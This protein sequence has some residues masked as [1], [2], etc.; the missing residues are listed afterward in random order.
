MNF[1]DNRKIFIRRVLLLVLL[2][3]TALFQHTDGAIPRLFGTKAMLLVPLVVA[4]SVHGRSF[5]GLIFGTL[6]GILWDCATVRGDGFFSVF[7]AV[8]GFSA[9][10]LVT[11]I[12]RNNIFTNLIISFFSIAAVNVTYWLVFILRK[13]YEGS[14]QVLFSYYLPSVLYTM[15]FAFVYYYIVG[16][17]HKATAPEQKIRQR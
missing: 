16:L 13:G 6:A 3:F 11:H 5:N 17:I 7:L 14:V 10:C 4:I 8:I 2:V 15:L 9:G 1:S 12:M